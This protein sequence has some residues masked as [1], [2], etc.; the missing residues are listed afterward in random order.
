MSNPALYEAAR[1]EEPDIPRCAACQAPFLPAELHDR[2]QV[3][4]RCEHQVLTLLDAVSDLWSQLPEHLLK[5]AANT[6]GGGGGGGHLEGS[7]APG[8]LTVLSLLAGEAAARLATWDTHWRERLGWTDTPLRGRPD[9]AL[10]QILRFLR[11]HLPWAVRNAGDLVAGLRDDARRLVGY[12]RTATA[13][14]RSLVPLPQPCPYRTPHGPDDQPCGGRLLM[15]RERRE[16]RCVHCSATVPMHNWVE[17]GIA[18]G[19]FQPDAA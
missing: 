2:R 3:C 6:G 14:A 9:H 15:D 17:L 5:P 7:A 19:A 8:N 4:T 16:I 1:L 12:M 10:R 11:D 13:D 18:V